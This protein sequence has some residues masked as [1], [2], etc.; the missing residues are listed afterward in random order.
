MKLILHS[1]LGILTAFCL[2]FIL[3][4][5]SIEAVCYWTPD[6][7]ENEYAK[8]QVLNHLPSM[9]ME[10]LLE[11][12]EEMMDYL[13]GNRKDLHV[14]T[15]MGGEVR[16]FFTEREIA[17]MEDVHVL[18]MAAIFLR[19]ICLMLIFTF[20]LAIYFTKGKLRKILP[21]S[22]FFGTLIFFAAAAGLGWIISTDFSKYFVLFHH[23][24]FDND[25]WI[26]DPS[27]DMLINIVP[28][29]FFMDTAFRILITFGI[30]AVL[31]L[32]LSFFFMKKNKKSAPLVLALAILT[33]TGFSAPS[34]AQVPWPE[35]SGI[36]ADGGILIDASSGAVLYEK[37]A[38]HAYYPA[39]IT[40]ILTALIIIENCDMNEIVTFS[41]NA[42]NNVESGSSNMGALVGD[43]LTVRDCLYGLML[44]S[45]NEAANALAEHY[46]GSIEAFTQIMNEKARE[47]GC[48]GSNF[49]NPSGLNNE[50]HYTTARDMACITKAAIK[51]PVFVEIDGSLYWKHAP[52]KRYPDPEDPHNVVYAHHGML[53]KNDSRYYPGAFAGKTG[54]TSLAGNTLVTCAQKNNMTLIAVILNGHQTHYQ[55]TKTLFNYGFKNFKSIQVSEYDHSYTSIE[56]DMTISGLTASPISTLSMSEDCYITLPQSADFHEVQTEL[57]YELDSSAPED[58]IAQISY[59]YNGRSI[60]SA[61]LTIKKTQDISSILETNAG[62]LPL[63]ESI[64][65]PEPTTKALD[66][67][68][69]REQ[70][71][72]HAIFN[73]SEN[74]DEP[75]KIQIPSAFWVAVGLTI[76]LSTFITVAVLLKIHKEKKEEEQQYIFREKRKK[77]LHEI[78]F[79]Q[80]DFDRIVNK[81][82]SRKN[83]PFH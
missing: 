36:Q 81:Q 24:F 26:L 8:Y 25:L 65:I 76:I 11:V 75:L 32:V 27:A 10:D 28:E 73:E 2:M 61:Y 69:E 31:V 71:T 83:R 74:L 53:K 29:P 9:T 47:L 7:Y 23:I 43:Q 67:Q 30:L 20:I 21:Q 15:T 12:T 66:P 44:A 38:D 48:T 18:F 1:F 64:T 52:I 56:N 51:N 62:I 46:A 70:E 50:N 57:H 22:I 33:S 63:E 80:N 14:W 82:K 16:E 60:G 35:C 45:A 37:N 55:D 13:R 6:Y 42:V 4:I 5:T 59:Q 19:R 58:S 17:H 41:D 68:T 79:S 78:G 54:Y 3:L 77:R 40:K 34:Y 39:S 72:F 49:A